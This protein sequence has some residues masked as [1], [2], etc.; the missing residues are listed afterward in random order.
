MGSAL[1]LLAAGVAPAQHPGAVRLLA[2]DVRFEPQFAGIKRPRMIEDGL[3]T[4]LAGAGLFPVVHGVMRGLGVAVRP[5]FMSDFPPRGVTIGLTPAGTFAPDLD[6]P[7]SCHGLR[8]LA[9]SW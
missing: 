9:E 5:V 2:V 6:V 4:S 1:L 8:R 7:I 3:D